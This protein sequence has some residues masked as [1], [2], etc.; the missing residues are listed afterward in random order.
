MR[1][2][3]ASHSRGKPD[4]KV[5]RF[6]SLDD[7]MYKYLEIPNH[8]KKVL[9]IQN[10]ENMQESI[11]FIV[12]ENGIDKLTH[13]YEKIG[14]WLNPEVYE[15]EQTVG[16]KSVQKENDSQPKSRK[17]SVLQALRERQVKIKE[18]EQNAAKEK[19]RTHKKGEVSL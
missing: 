17:E 10:T 7:A 12:C 9:G 14:G 18:Q 2:F 16:D 15:A 8:Q 5:E 19:S 4:N 6:E 3:P 13:E 1:S 11:D